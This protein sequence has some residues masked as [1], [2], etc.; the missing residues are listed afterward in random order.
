MLITFHTHLLW[1]FSSEGQGFDNH[2][3][4]LKTLAIREG[5]RLPIFE[6]P[7]YSKFDRT[8]LLASTLSP[9]RVFQHISV[10]GLC[11]MFPPDG[12]GMNYF[13]KD[14]RI[15]SEVLSYSAKKEF[16]CGKYEAALEKVFD[17]IYAVL[18]GKNFKL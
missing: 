2:L 17:D 11:P 7:S 6:D 1:S 9:P 12:Y 16:E 3:L 10:V 14:D 13:V 15:I 4:A 8:L 18:N 5:T